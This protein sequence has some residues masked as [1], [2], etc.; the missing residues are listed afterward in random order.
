MNTQEIGDKYEDF[1]QEIYESIRE[2]EKTGLIKS[3]C[4]E[5]KKKISSIY[6]VS[7]EIDLYWEYVDPQTHELKKV[8]IECKGYKSAVPIEKIDAFR[9]KI[10]DT[11]ITEGMFFSKTGFQSGAIKCAEHHGIKLC[12]LRKPLD[13]DYEGRVKTIIIKLSIKMHEIISIGLGVAKEHD[14][15]IRI[16]GKTQIKQDDQVITAVGDLVS[17]DS[18]GKEEGEYR[19][20]KRFD[21]AHIESEGNKI[22]FSEIEIKYRI[23]PPKEQEIT[24][25]GDKINVAFLE[26]IGFGKFFIKNS[27]KVSSIQPLPPS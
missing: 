13:K 11:K 14:G 6:G 27:G 16:C 4:I 3:T 22:P 10:Q 5:K 2:I 21:N 15:P 12:H 18:K 20:Q 24:I 7:R 23:G 1:T 17:D 25:D 9:T 26:H 19:I 8:A